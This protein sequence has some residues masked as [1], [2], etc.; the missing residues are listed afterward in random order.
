MVLFYCTFVAMKYQDRRG[1]PEESLH[2][3]LELEGQ[4]GDGEELLFGGVI[5]HDNMQHALRLFRDSTSHVV[6][7]EASAYRGSMQDVPIWTAFATKYAYAN[8][9]AWAQYDGS[10]SV[11]LA[12][13]KPPPYVFAPQYKPPRNRRGEYVLPFITSRGMWTV[14]M[15]L[16]YVC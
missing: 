3:R 12:A 4:G 5:Q 7:I 9:L 13:F 16:L 2:D 8:D 6:R 10:G 15:C 11:S 14:S 1:L